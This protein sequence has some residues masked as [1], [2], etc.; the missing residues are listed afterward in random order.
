MHK[1]KQARKNFRDI[2]SDPKLATVKITGPT[3]DI[4]AKIQDLLV[5]T[6]GDRVVLSP[7][8]RSAPSGFHA[9]VSILGER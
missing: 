8:L 7:I 9:F 2:K 6:Y 3:T 5:E 1:N 4:V